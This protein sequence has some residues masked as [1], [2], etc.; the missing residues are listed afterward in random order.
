MTAPKHVDKIPGS[1]HVVSRIGAISIGHITAGR[2]AGI[3]CAWDDRQILAKV[4]PP[5]TEEQALGVSVL[6]AAK[7]PRFSVP[8]GGLKDLEAAAKQ[9]REGMEPGVPDLILVTS[10]PIACEFKKANGSFDDVAERQWKWLWAMVEN[11]WVAGIAFGYKAMLGYLHC[12][13]LT[14]PTRTL[15]L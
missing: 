11:G 5:E 6:K 13:G 3:W 8:N 10:P 7:I 9:K 1:L 12:K 14:V 2:S 4:A 15:G